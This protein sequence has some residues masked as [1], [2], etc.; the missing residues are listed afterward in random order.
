MEEALGLVFDEVVQDLLE[1]LRVVLAEEGEAGEREERLAQEAGE[2]PGVTGDDPLAAAADADQQVRLPHELVV[3]RGDGPDLAHRGGEL[4]LEAGRRDGAVGAGGDDHRVTRVEFQLEGA[5][6]E[7]VLAAVE[8]TAHLVGIGDAVVPAGGGLELGRRAQLDVQVREAFIQLPGPSAFDLPA[9]GAGGVVLLG[10]VVDFAEGKERLEFQLHLRG[11]VHQLVLDEDLVAVLH[12]DE[13]LPED[14]L[15]DLVGD[16]RN[17]VGVEVHD[18]LVAARLVDVAVTMDAQIEALAPEREA[19][20]QGRQE[21]VPVTVERLHR[22]GEESVVAAR[23]AGHDGRV[24]I[25]ARLARKEDLP[26]E[27][28]RQVDEL[29]LVEFQKSHM[30]LHYNFFKT[31]ALR[32][33][34]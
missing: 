28:V 26:L 9:R 27:R 16:H 1:L 20:V 13:A 8:A 19:F 21:H 3:E 12:E 6:D 11:S 29:R 31:T 24:A 2:E 34:R 5:R 23:V 22:N 18:V 25:R 17:R 10:E 30:R 32:A 14:D 33:G 4:A 7:E 15:T